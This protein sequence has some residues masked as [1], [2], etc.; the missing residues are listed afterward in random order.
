[1]SDLSRE[2]LA[3]LRAAPVARSVIA[4]ELATKGSVS[5]VLG[6]YAREMTPPHLV[7]RHTSAGGIKYGLRPTK[8]GEL[9]GQVKEA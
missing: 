6:R 4:T 9:S 2:F 5:I 1:M 3:N 8:P 7:E